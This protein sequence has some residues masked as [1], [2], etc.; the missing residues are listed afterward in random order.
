MIFTT[1]K[2]FNELG[3]SYAIKTYLPLSW[4][5]YWSGGRFL[6]LGGV[7]GRTRH[8]KLDEVWPRSPSEN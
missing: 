3:N 6:Q 1:D 5:G 4:T 8:L 2:P 7:S